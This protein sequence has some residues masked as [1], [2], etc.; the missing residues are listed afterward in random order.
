MQKK[1]LFSLVSS[2]S[3]SNI[4][5]FGPVQKMSKKLNSSFSKDMGS[6]K[7]TLF[8]YFSSPVNKKIPKTPTSNDN[9][10]DQEKSMAGKDDKENIKNGAAIEVKMDVSDEEDDF[11][12]SQKKRKRIVLLDSD[13]EEEKKSKPNKDDEASPQSNKHKKKSVQADSSPEPSCSPKV[14]DGDSSPEIKKKNVCI[15]LTST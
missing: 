5:Y 1:I 3:V 13:E 8:K 9:N 11:V 7:N 15:R 12:G 14:E 2:P 10:N 4:A 6:P